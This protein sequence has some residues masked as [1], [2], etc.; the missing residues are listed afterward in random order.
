MKS[1]RRV[2]RPAQR[3]VRRAMDLFAPDLTRTRDVTQLLPVTPKEWPSIERQIEAVEVAYLAAV[4][5]PNDNDC[6]AL[7][8]AAMTLR[9]IR[10]ELLGKN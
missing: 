9:R 4:V 5:K 7:H 6:D 8:A 1:L 2:F 3:D 10:R